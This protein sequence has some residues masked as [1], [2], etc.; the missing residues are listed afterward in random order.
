[1][2]CG[3]LRFLRFGEGGGRGGGREA[4]HPKGDEGKE[5]KGEGRTTQEEKAAP[6]KRRRR[7]YHCSQRYFTSS[8]LN[9]VSR[10]DHL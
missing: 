3:V 9:L 2:V 1:M 10:S 6:P 4:A 7:D 8:E 5:V